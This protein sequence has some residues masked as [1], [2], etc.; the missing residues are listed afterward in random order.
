M[1]QSHDPVSACHVRNAQAQASRNSR[2][3]AL[4]SFRQISLP[5]ADPMMPDHK[6]LSDISRINLAEFLWSSVRLPGNSAA[7]TDLRTFQ[8]NCVKCG[9]GR[10]SSA[11]GGRYGRFNN[12]CHVAKSD[13]GC[14]NERSV[15][16]RS[17]GLGQKIPL[18]PVIECD[19]APSGTKRR[20]GDRSN[21]DPSGGSIV[22]M[23]V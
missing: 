10:R 21:A 12:Q 3:P 20:Q 17:S 22:R 4:E 2:S 14:Q 11:A 7:F 5:A 16:E 9:V 19:G 8:K 13:P 1:H 23:R 6:E 15:H 18:K